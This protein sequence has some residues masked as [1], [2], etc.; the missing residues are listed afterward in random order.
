MPVMLSDCRS[1]GHVGAPY[2]CLQ[3]FH[4]VLSESTLQGR[5]G[6]GWGWGYREDSRRGPQ[7]C[8]VAKWEEWGWSACKMTLL[9]P[10]RGRQVRLSTLQDPIRT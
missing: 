6:A 10:D 3:S 1:S 7:T 2:N 8:P 5:N 9:S 4:K